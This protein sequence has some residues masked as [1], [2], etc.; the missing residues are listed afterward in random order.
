MGIDLIINGDAK[1]QLKKLNVKLRI[2]AVFAKSA[3]FENPDAKLPVFKVKKIQNG[4]RYDEDGVRIPVSVIC[5]GK[6]E[7]P[8]VE[9]GGVESLRNEPKLE[10]VKARRTVDIPN[11]AL[12]AFLNGAVFKYLEECKQDLGLAEQNKAEFDPEV[13]ELTFN[14]SQEGIDEMEEDYDQKAGPFAEFN[15]L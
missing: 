10:F 13:L 8:V 11:T 2:R 1:L 3:D 12:T 15:I 7:L 5:L 9:G 4:V 14:L 6:K